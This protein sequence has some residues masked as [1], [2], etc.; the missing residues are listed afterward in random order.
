MSD[1]KEKVSAIDTIDKF[2]ATVLLNKAGGS[3][4][5]LKDELERFVRERERGG[6]KYKKRKKNFK[7][8]NEAVE[9]SLKTKEREMQELSNRVNEKNK[10][11]NDLRMLL[12]KLRIKIMVLKKEGEEKLFRDLS[13]KIKKEV[14]QKD[15]PEFL[16]NLQNRK[17]VM[18]FYLRCDWLETYKKLGSDKYDR[19][20]KNNWYRPWY[21][22]L[23]QRWFSKKKV[24][25]EEREKHKEERVNAYS[26]QYLG[27]L[28][29]QLHQE[30]WIR[31]LAYISLENASLKKEIDDIYLK[32]YKSFYFF[33]S[34]RK[35]R[36]KR[37]RKIKRLKGKRESNKKRYRLIFNLEA[38]RLL[39]MDEVGRTIKTLQT[40]KLVDSGTMTTMLNNH[41][42]DSA[43]LGDTKQRK[44][45]AYWIKQVVN[46]DS[47][48]MAPGNL[49]KR[50]EDDP[51]YQGLE[52][53]RRLE[54][55]TQ[56]DMQPRRRVIRTSH[57]Y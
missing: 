11:S 46:Q 35:V 21:Q 29:G 2:Y 53:P 57:T 4:E 19:V 8:R 23:Y 3:R 43:F 17:E 45:A 48:K 20:Y 27:K 22:R 36:E 39:V 13:D 32:P 44:E 56:Q 42:Y 6:K 5:A 37:R 49:M 41:K 10:P 34:E 16:S 14:K 47:V 26:Q 30:N 1:T 25:T 33:T 55:Q 40:K 54:T 9:K 18:D 38:R 50:N 7:G 24:T 15:K 52:E 31:V 12:K 28:F 51:R